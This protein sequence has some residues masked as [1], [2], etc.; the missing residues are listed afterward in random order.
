MIDCSINLHDEGKKKKTVRTREKQISISF[1]LFEISCL[2]FIIRFEK[3]EA[4]KE[5]GA[6]M[7]KKKKKKIKKARGPRIETPAEI[8]TKR[9]Q[10]GTAEDSRDFTPRP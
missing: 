5:I 2:R 7:K 9:E 8:R 4:R 10:V 1:P 6:R 3:A